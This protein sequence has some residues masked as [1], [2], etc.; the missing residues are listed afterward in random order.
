MVAVPMKPQYGPTL[1]QLLS[2]RWRAASPLARRAV[3][4]SGV[5]LLALLIIAG[6]TLENARY[7]RGGR[8]P[9]GFSY[10]SL[11]R[12]APEPGGFVKM[13]RRRPDG[14]LED[15]LAVGPLRLPPYSGSLAGELPLYATGYISGLRLRH[16]QFV[17]RGEGKTKVDTIFAYAVSYTTVVEGQTMWGRDILLLPERAGAREGVDIMMLTSPTAD[18]QVDSPTEVGSAGV[19]SRPL[20]TFS[21]G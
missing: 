11:Y 1:G 5:A 21:F 2:P 9:F 3:I 15:S 18:S 14:R 16:A 19:L 7:S 12:V 17:L 4:A 8:V 10:R 13:Q 6:L 20:R